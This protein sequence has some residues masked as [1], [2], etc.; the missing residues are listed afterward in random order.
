MTYQYKTSG[1]CASQIQFDLNDGVVTNI[2][3][4]G[5]C[6]GNLK[7]ISKIPEGW[8]A[9]DIE[10]TLLGNTCGPRPT[11]CPDQ[12]ARAVAQARADEAARSA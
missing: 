1:T 8:K 3:F 12:L 5:G 7:A 10:K 11:S 2:R 9:E 4:R 6:S